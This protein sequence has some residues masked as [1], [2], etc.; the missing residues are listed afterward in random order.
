MQTLKILFDQYPQR[1]AVTERLLAI[2]PDLFG[3]EPFS[4]LPPWQSYGDSS[5]LVVSRYGGK[6]RVHL[7]R[8]DETLTKGRAEF[9][10][11]LGPARFSE[12]SHFF[13]V[14]AET[15]RIGLHSHLHAC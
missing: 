12:F 15:N 14:Q 9:N 6:F 2:D 8:I 7:E 1:S 5:L 13:A 3:L 10:Q 4:C 11:F